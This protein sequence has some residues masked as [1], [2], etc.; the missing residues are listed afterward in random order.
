M[1]KA[2]VKLFDYLI[3]HLVSCSQII[4]SI[5]IAVLYPFQNQTHPFLKPPTGKVQVPAVCLNLLK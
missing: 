5:C 1:G 4:L 2:L 3:N